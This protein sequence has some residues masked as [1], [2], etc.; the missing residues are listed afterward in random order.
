VE[1]KRRGV[2][3]VLS[4]PSGAGKTTLSRL[5]LDG[6]A[7]LHLSVSVTTRSPRPG[8]TEGV[9]YHFVDRERFAA[10]RDGEE[11]LEWAEIFG[12]LYGTPKAEVNRRLA[13]GEDILFDIDW[14]GAA[15]L[16]AQAPED[17]VSAFILPPSQ[18]VLAHRLRSRGADSEEVIRRRLTGA[19]EEIRQWKAYDYVIINDDLNA[20]HQ[21][22][23][24]I[25]AAERLKRSRRSGLNDFIQGLLADF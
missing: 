18:P 17:L 13:S 22:L 23:R 19:A 7:D 5:L 12:N 4:S 15:Q 3:L 10:L 16:R 11:L 24:A 8:E 1:L 25:L 20:S 14:Q 9:H 2:M 21:A 6:D